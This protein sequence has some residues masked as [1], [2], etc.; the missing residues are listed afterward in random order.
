MIEEI[1][2]RFVVPIIVIIGTFRLL[3]NMASFLSFI[4]QQCLRKR[5][6]HLKRYGGK[7]TWALVTGASDGIGLE[8]C[9]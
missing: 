7:G 5:M 9:R 2:S 3:M 6:D 8:F 1:W 4:N